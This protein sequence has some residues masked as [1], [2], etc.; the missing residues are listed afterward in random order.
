[1]GLVTAALAT[2]SSSEPP[3]S[4]YEV[5]LPAASRRLPSDDRPPA[6]FGVNNRF[7]D[8][9]IVESELAKADVA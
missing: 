2:W 4:P 6:V 1:M 5:A 8:N 9:A 7:G 3:R